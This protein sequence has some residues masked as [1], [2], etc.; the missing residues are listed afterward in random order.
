MGFIYYG[1]KGN[2]APKFEFSYSDKLA[3]SY[4]PL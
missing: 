2:D 1:W 4:T 3:G